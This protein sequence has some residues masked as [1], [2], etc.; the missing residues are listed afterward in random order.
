MKLERPL[1]AAAVYVMT[2]LYYSTVD[3][4]RLEKKRKRKEASEGVIS[5]Y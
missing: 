2:N 3:Q 5:S 1:A 4:S